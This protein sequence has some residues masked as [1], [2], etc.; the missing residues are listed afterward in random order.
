MVNLQQWLRRTSPHLIVAGTILV[1]GLS[2]CRSA[3][4][5][6]VALEPGYSA[7]DYAQASPLA[8]PLGM[9]YDE[10]EA[11]PLPAET[12]PES[13]VTVDSGTGNS[14]SILGKPEPPTAATD[15]TVQARPAEV[16]LPEETIPEQP[17]AQ[18]GPSAT[19]LP[20]EESLFPDDVAKNASKGEGTA[21]NLPDDLVNVEPRGEVELS[22]KQQATV[23]TTESNADQKDV[24][25]TPDE[26]GGSVPVN[27]VFPPFESFDPSATN[28]EVRVPGPGQTPVLPRKADDLE[29]A[30]DAAITVESPESSSV[31]VPKNEATESAETSENSVSILDSSS[32]SLISPGNLD[33]PEV[34]SSVENRSRFQIDDAD[35]GLPAITP[36]QSPQIALPEI[37]LPVA[38]DDGR[39]ADEIEVP[40]VESPLASLVPVRE[41]EQDQLA[42]IQKPELP[43]PSTS[44]SKTIIVEPELPELTAPEK[45]AEA[46]IAVIAEFS[47]SIDSVTFDQDGNAFVAHGQQISRVSRNGEVSQWAKVGAPR[48]HAVLPDGNHVICDGSQRAVVKLNSDGEMIGKVATR[49][50]GYFLRSPN[51]LVVDAQGGIYFTDPGYAR[52]RNPIGK[53]HYVASDGSV[54]I[55]AQRLAFP[56]GI[57][58]SPDGDSLLVV[59][60]QT[61]QILK[62]EI[63]SPGRVGPKRIFARL[64]DGSGGFANGM[65]VDSRGRVFVA[66]GGTQQVEVISADGLRLRSHSVN[67]AISSV[68]FRG[69]D[70]GRVFAAGASRNSSNKGQLF[71]IRLPE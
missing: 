44:P 61:S 71:E 13:P 40:V 36:R 63:L 60:S 20:D 42:S 24:V 67:A 35:G 59:E 14:S 56:E 8:E 6:A 23:A 25:A 51:D 33:L 31:V 54:N 46:A 16:P 2:G 12:A 38:A 47:A 64:N 68:S 62:F 18:T 55:V 41:P 39:Q 58:I 21:P 50:D 26:D 17:V 29:D 52:I 43:Q 9:P 11:E 10:V 30:I 3:H 15:S 7:S 45:P 34:E 1:S 49:S 32:Q 37:D 5:G 22:Q 27:E 70:F 69:D 66:H 4:Q 48:G 65:T 57:A 28:P 53:V 19:P